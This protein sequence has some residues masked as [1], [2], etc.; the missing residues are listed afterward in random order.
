MSKWKKAWG[1]VLGALFI[2]G[3]AGVPTNIG[4]WGKA[5]VFITH[6]MNLEILR[7]GFSVFGLLGL[8]VIF[9]LPYLKPSLNIDLIPISGARLDV[10]LAVKNQGNKRDFYAQCTPLALRNS[11]NELARGTFDLKWEHTFERQI[12]IGAGATCNLLIATVDIDHRNSLATMQICGLSGSEKKQCEWSRWNTEPNE[13]LPEY[14]LEISVFSDGTKGP[15]SARF[16]L[17]PKD[18]YGPLEMI[19]IV[20]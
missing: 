16:T 2:I 14:E 13:K 7:I 17:R 1:I 5:F 15:V 12:S 8:A 20:T 18:W 4:R 10:L 3:L 19:K 11:P 6:Y 9:L